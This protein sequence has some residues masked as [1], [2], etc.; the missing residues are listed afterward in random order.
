VSGVA[1][2]C[3]TTGIRNSLFSAC[4]CSF[5]KYVALAMDKDTNDL[6][7]IDFGIPTLT[8]DEL[9]AI[10][11]KANITLDSYYAVRWDGRVVIRAKPK[12]KPPETDFLR[13][14]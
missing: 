9:V 8:T 7:G 13:I 6:D 4:A 12:D 14:V 2:C 5:C 10:M 3:Q 11:R 1:R